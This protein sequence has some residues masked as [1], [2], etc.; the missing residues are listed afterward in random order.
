[1]KQNLMKWAVLALCAF[2]YTSCGDDD[3]KNKKE[4]TK[5]NQAEKCGNGKVCNDQGKCVDDPSI[6]R[7]TQAN[8]AEKCGADKICS[9]DGICVAKP[10][11]T[12]NDGC[13]G[14]LVC[15]AEGKCV[16]AA[17]CTD[18]D[19]CEGDLVCSADGQCIEAVECETSD[20]CEGDLIC[21][22]NKCIAEGACSKNDDCNI[23]QICNDENKCEN[24]VLVCGNGIRE[25]A[26][27]CDRADFSEMAKVCG[28]G[29]VEKDNAVW[30][31]TSECKIDKSQACIADPSKPGI[32]IISEFALQVEYG[33]GVEAFYAEIA[34]VGEGDLD[35]SKCAVRAT[36]DNDPNSGNH[37][38]VALE[39][40]LEPGSVFVV[41]AVEDDDVV[42]LDGVTCDKI[43]ADTEEGSLLPNSGFKDNQLFVL[44]CNDAAVDYVYYAA[45]ILNWFGPSFVRSCMSATPNAS[46]MP[47]DTTHMFTE[48]ATNTLGSYACSNAECMKN[49]DCDDGAECLFGVCVVD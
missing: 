31:C 49:D 44:V 1:M 28:A 42:T 9:A 7:C 17:K 19:G 38:S 30:I 18:D 25:G 36:G 46:V 13:E 4:C 6:I 40:I 47:N 11:C 22:D 34:N 5:E 45:G 10:D 27:E 8:A 35:L 23:G 48:Q 24:K 32:G 26:E 39:G 2:V 29:M 14:D 33:V 3:D 37:A 16:E 15:S 43:I 21:S 12:D 20:Q 41:C